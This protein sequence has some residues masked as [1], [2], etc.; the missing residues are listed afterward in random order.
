MRFTQI[1]D[2]RTSRLDEMMDLQRQWEAESQDS[3]YKA[4]VQTTR[5]RDDPEHCIVIVT[6]DSYDEAMANSERPETTEFSQMMSK[7]AD[8]PPR[9]INLDV[10]HEIT[11]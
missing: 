8:G 5:D 2:V 11:V 6:F 9:F 3:P 10:M 1:I 7:L 4:T